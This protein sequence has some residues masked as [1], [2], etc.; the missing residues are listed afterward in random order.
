MK[1][2][3]LVLT[4]VLLM[5]IHACQSSQKADQQSLAQ[6][7]AE[8]PTVDS[9]V[10]DTV[11]NSRGA[12]LIMAYDNARHTA[13]FILADEVIKLRQDTLA[14]GIKYSNAEY[15]YT[16]HQGKMTLRKGN[17]IVFSHP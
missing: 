2:F 16:E 8:A 14:A 9:T 17:K 3:L 12:K 11:T 13:L 5:G 1:P 7:P 6:S 15:E 4:I 10:W